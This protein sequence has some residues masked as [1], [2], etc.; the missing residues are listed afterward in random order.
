MQQP[1]SDAKVLGTG[2]ETP[3][4]MGTEDPGA[5][6]LGG[7]RGAL[8]QWAADAGADIVPLLAVCCRTVGLGMISE[9]IEQPEVV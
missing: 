5:R 6:L 9:A 4:S 2:G 3:A 8:P 1:P 7:P